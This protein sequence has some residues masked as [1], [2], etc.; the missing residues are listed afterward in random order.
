[1]SDRQET[2]TEATPDHR[3]D[4]PI[5]TAGEDKLGRD[6][7]VGRLARALV[8]DGRASGVVVGLT[9]PW[10][11]GKSS[12]LNL[13]E[14]E[15][16]EK[17]PGAVV[18]RFDPW[19]VSGRD[20]VIGQFF[21]ELLATITEVGTT[22]GRTGDTLLNVGNKLASYAKDIGHAA[23]FFLPGAGSALSG[24]AKAAEAATARDTSLAR[25]RRD[26]AA[27]LA[28]VAVPIVV[29]V[30]ELDRVEDAEV[31]AV[32][33]LV[34]AVADFPGLSYLLAYDRRR[35]IEA[36]GGTE[37]GRGSAYLEK[38]VQL[39][40]PLPVTLNEEADG[41]LIAEFE[42]AAPREI[43]PAGWREDRRFR[44]IVAIALDGLVATPRDVRR[45][46]GIYAVLA[47]MVLGEVDWA[48]LFGYA[49]LVAKASAVIDAIR[50]QPTLV[51]R[52][53]VANLSTEPDWEDF[54]GTRTGNPDELL[55]RLGV[56]PASPP[57]R[58]L[59]ELFP[60]LRS[61][62]TARARY[63][64]EPADRLRRYRSLMTVLRLGLLPGAVSRAEIV[65]FLALK[66]ETK[67]E[68]VRAQVADQR[69][70]SFLDRLADIY[71]DVEDRDPEGTLY[72]FGSLPRALTLISPADIPLAYRNSGW[73]KDFTEI[74]YR[75]RGGGLDVCRGAMLAL[76]ADGHFDAPASYLRH[77]ISNHG[78]FDQPAD[79]P[80]DAW[81]PA[82]TVRE[83]ATSL[84]AGIIAAQEA[85]RL[86]EMVRTMHPFLLAFE[87]RGWGQEHRD[88]LTQM[89][90]GD[91][92]ALEAFTLVAY[93]VGFIEADVVSRFADPT[94]LI[95]Q[96]NSIDATAPEWADPVMKA[97]RSKALQY[98]R[99]A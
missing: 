57:A 46:C 93:G 55:R 3:P 20:D 94:M 74:A 43:L 75:R 40:L 79:N 72:L 85:G 53:A 59:G 83:L 96:L 64:R 36:L 6:G 23:N 61:D 39:E 95:L 22:N 2:P 76:I 11:S 34:R 24:L 35:V 37:G 31:R 33:Q 41:L 26:L 99:P 47:P 86:L 58:L 60:R 65:G 92:A 90:R 48:D 56:D 91:D 17:H 15:I 19:L 51:V 18:V 80:E 68:R 16:K 13:L 12:I 32:A 5:A 1:M 25:Q 21:T 88:A 38:I 10:G 49:V 9:G 84:G 81:L 28:G 8:R 97:A 87:V 52:D 71:G 45:V 27:M 69:L 29:L 82:A 77:Q 50:Q 44:R 7:F 89:I 78:L 66:A 54:S 98:L 63:E 14:A 73:F 42:A 67:L 70:D 30:D 62:Q 4:R